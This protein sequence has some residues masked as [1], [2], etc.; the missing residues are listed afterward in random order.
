MPSGSRLLC[1]PSCR[2]LIDSSLAQTNTPELPPGFWCIHCTTNSKFVTG[3]FI[4]MTPVGVPVH[5][6]LPSLNDHV[7]AAQFT[8]T[9]LASPSARQPGPFPSTNAFGSG[10]SATANDRK[11]IEG[12]SEQTEDE[13]FM[14]SA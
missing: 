8:L 13:I 10:S 3:S 7:S 6:I 12:Q 9:K 2:F 14:R 1:V 4:R 5:W 11:R